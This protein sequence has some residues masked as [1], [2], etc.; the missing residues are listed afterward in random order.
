MAKED[1]LP[2]SKPIQKPSQEVTG[3]SHANTPTMNTTTAHL[4]LGTSVPPTIRSSAP[5][6]VTD[7]WPCVRILALA[8]RLRRS[9][10]DL[11]ESITRIR[12]LSRE[13]VQHQ[14]RLA[15]EILAIDDEMEAV[16]PELRECLRNDPPAKRRHIW[17]IVQRLHQKTETLSASTQTHCPSHLLEG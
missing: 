3:R 13:Q 8:I 5:P 7:W 17:A 12:D 11:F 4:P 10:G 15:Q 16:L 6:S 2:S 1:S 14:D 9:F